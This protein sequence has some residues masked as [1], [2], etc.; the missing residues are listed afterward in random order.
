MK[1]HRERGLY[2][3]SDLYMTSAETAVQ[4]REVRL[5]H[6]RA[7]RG[8]ARAERRGER[9]LQRQSRGPLA[10]GGCNEHGHG[11]LVLTEMQPEV[12]CIGSHGK[13]LRTVG[14]KASSTWTDGCIPFCGWPGWPGPQPP[15]AWD[16]GD[17]LHTPPA[18]QAESPSTQ[19]A[20]T[21]TPTWPAQGSEQNPQIHWI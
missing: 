21:S 19:E 16:L 9:V 14:S 13:Q 12:M 17:S 5:A 8:S 3:H 6:S 15:Q 4:G 7:G 11:R 1:F 2:L 10:L 18:Q 20:A